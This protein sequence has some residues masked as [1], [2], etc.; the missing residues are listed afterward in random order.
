MAWWTSMVAGLA[1]VANRMM[2]RKWGS[3][4]GQESKLRQAA[5]EAAKQ[6]WAALAQLREAN[7]RG[8]KVKVAEA[9]DL[10]NRWDSELDR[11]RAQ[12]AAER[13]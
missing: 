11:L 8:D 6:K 4:T 5:E 13:D 9:L 12:A 1:E 7:D 3:Q 2:Q 10:I